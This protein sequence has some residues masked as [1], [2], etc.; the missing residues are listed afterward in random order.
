MFH[1]YISPPLFAPPLLS[2]PPAFLSPSNTTLL[3]RHAS[4]F[5]LNTFHRVSGSISSFYLAIPSK[6]SLCIPR[7]LHMYSLVSPAP[8]PPKTA[9]LAHPLQ[10]LVAY[11]GLWLAPSCSRFLTLPTSSDRRCCISWVAWVPR[12]GTLLWRL[13]STTRE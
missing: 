7:A 12:V 10:R 2:L 4:P 6:M 8:N 13:P 5:N 3:D 9:F 11:Q 1:R